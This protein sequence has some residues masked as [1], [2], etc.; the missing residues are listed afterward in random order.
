MT[1]VLPTFF[2]E[3]GV[4]V[5]AQ[6]RDQW[7]PLHL[8]SFFGR[9]EI[10]RVLLDHGAKPNAEDNLLKTPLHH[11]AGS[12]F[13]SQQDGVR[14]AQLLLKHGANVN[15]QDINH[16]TPLHS[17]SLCGRLEIARMLLEHAAVK[18]DRGQNPSHLDLEG[19]YCT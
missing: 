11:V 17:A 19:E 12:R 5:N 1:F 18:N 2:L 14:V 13:E 9:P 8:A 6:R 15:A 3:R 16:E 7:T 10:A 4:D